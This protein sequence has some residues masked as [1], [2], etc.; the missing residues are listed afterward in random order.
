MSRKLTVRAREGMRVPR[1]G[2]PRR[3]I[4]ETTPVTV[5]SSPYYRRQLRDGDL[6][7]VGPTP[8]A[9]LSPASTRRTPPE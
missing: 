2:A 3:Y 6:V 1:E 7:E 8:A 4:D 9:P 5:T